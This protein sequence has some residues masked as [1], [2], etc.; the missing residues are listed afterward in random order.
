VFDYGVDD[1]GKQKGGHVGFVVGKKG[2]KLVI[3]GGNQGD[4]VSYSAFKTDKIAAYVVPDGYTPPTFDLPE[5]KAVHK[6]G[7]Y[8]S[9]R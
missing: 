6:A 8:A 9:T 5:I 7:D 4:A 3:L 1:E 2:S